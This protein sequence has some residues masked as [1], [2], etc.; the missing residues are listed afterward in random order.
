MMTMDGNAANMAALLKEWRESKGISKYAIAKYE[1]MRIEVVTAVEEGRAT[2][3]GLS[4]YLDY[5]GWQDKAFLKE[6]TSKWWES[7]G[8]GNLS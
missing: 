8:F 3:S 1:N 4:N 7:M 5:I 6:F 2:M